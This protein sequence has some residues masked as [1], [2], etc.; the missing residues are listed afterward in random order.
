[1]VDRRCSDGD[2]GGELR[3]EEIEIDLGNYVVF[4][5]SVVVKADAAAS[6]EGKGG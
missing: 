2:V 3:V 1:M 5:R 6:A 4:Q